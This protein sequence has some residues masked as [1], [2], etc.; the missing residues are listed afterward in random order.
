[1]SVMPA[2]M[3]AVV[4]YIA[5]SDFISCLEDFCKHEKSAMAALFSKLNH[6]KYLNMM[7]QRWNF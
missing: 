3:I 7:L 1:M 2:A 5:S 4:L 6:S